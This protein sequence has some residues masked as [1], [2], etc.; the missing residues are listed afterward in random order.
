MGMGGRLV[1]LTTFPN[2]PQVFEARHLVFRDA[3]ILGSRYASRSE[4][5]E[6]AQMVANGEVTSVVGAVSGPDDILDIHRQL[7]AGDLVGRGA[8]DWSRA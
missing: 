1:V 8:L 5:I 2:R 7:E 4:V 6:A 3:S